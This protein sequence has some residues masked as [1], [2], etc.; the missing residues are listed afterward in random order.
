MQLWYEN[1]S[2]GRLDLLNAADWYLVTQEGL[3]SLPS[4]KL[5][6]VETAYSEGAWLQNRKREARQVVLTHR[7]IHNVRD[8]RRRFVNTL[9]QSSTG[10]IRYVDADMNVYLDVEVESCEVKNTDSA[11][12]SAV[13]TFMALYPYFRGYDQTTASR[14][15]VVGG[16]KFPFTFPITFGTTE[17][18]GYVELVNDGAVP[19]GITYTL[20][21]TRGDVS[22]IKL[23]NQRGE[24]MALAG[25]TL[26][27]GHSV[28][29]SSLDGDKHV[30]DV[31]G[32]GNRVTL[33]NYFAGQF[34]KAY[35]GINRFELSGTDVVN[36]DLEINVR[37]AY[38]AV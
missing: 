15:Q 5:T 7:F 18:G 23:A 12:T 1:E 34:L 22:D 11:V 25:Y 27:Q 4:N 13:T 26:K 10:R 28:M 38:K 19:V 17:V 29:F 33:L 6:T 36:A 8:A 30:Y 16:F 31:D 2:G 14:T 35:E 21:A 9:Q 3:S 32:N 24:Y 37:P 20:K